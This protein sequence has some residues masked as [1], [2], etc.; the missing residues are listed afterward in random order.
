MYK[1]IIEQKRRWR[2]RKKIKGTS[3]KPRV[4][5]LFTNKNIHVQCIDD[6]SNTTIAAI[7]TCSKQFNNK[8]LKPNS[9]TA[10]ILSKII[11]SNLFKIGI[12]VCVYDRA[13]HN[14]HGRVKA[15]ADSLRSNG[16]KF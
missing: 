5:I 9:N 7:S 14:Y 4:T 3:V 6:A 16:M 10:T 2:I 15:F 11:S 13:G 8:N 1:N 12:H